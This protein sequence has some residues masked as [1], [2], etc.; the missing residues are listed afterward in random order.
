MQSAIGD[1]GEGPKVSHNNQTPQQQIPG[2]GIGITRRCGEGFD[3][4][5]TSAPVGTQNMDKRGTGHVHLDVQH[6]L[7]SDDHRL[8]RGHYLHI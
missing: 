6:I 3:S 4:T 7:L 5:S 8:D 2:I 1:V